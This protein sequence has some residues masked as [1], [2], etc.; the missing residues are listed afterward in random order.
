V[1]PGKSPKWTLER[2]LKASPEERRAAFRGNHDN[3]GL[4]PLAPD[5][6]LDVDDETPDGR[7]MEVFKAYHPNL[8]GDTLRHRTGRGARFYLYCPDVPQDQGKIV[9][10]EYLGIHDLRVEI[11]VG[12]GENIIIP[13]SVHLNGTVYIFE[14]IRALKANWLPTVRALDH[15]TQSDPEG[16]RAAS[17]A[18][19]DPN[20]KQAFRGNL[21]TLDIVAL[22]DHFGLLGE[23]RHDT[24]EGYKCYTCQCPWRDEHTHNKT[25]EWSERDTSSVIMF[26]SGNL[27][28]FNCKHSHGDQYKLPQFL[29]WCEEQE[30]GIVDQHCAQQWESRRSKRSETESED[31]RERGIDEPDGYYGPVDCSQETDSQVQ[32]SWPYPRDSIL[33]DFHQYTVQLSEAADCYIIGSILPIVG[34]LLGRNVYIPFGDTIIFPNLFSMIVGPAGDR[35]SFTIGIAQRLLQRL[36]APEALLSQIASSEAMFDEYDLCPDKIHVVDD[37]AQLLAGWRTTQ[38]GEKVAALFLRLYDCCGLDEA[39]VRNR[40]LTADKGTRRY[41]AQTSTS[42]L[43][44]ATPIDA[45][46]PAQK[47]QQGLSRRFLFYLSLVTAR[48]IEWPE[49]SSIDAMVPLFAPLLDFRGPVTLSK[50]ARELWGEFQRDNRRRKAEVP[51]ERESERYALSSEPVQV[52]KISTHFEACRAVTE[53]KTFL[54]GIRA[55]TLAL[56]IQHVGAC[57]ASAKMLVGRG[58]RHETRQQAEEIL[59]KIRDLFAPDTVYPDTIYVSRSRLTRKFC[60]HTSRKGALQ[61]D[62]LYLEIIPYLC[63]T[64]EAKRVFKQGKYEVYAFRATDTLPLVSPSFATNSP[65]G[66]PSFATNSPQRADESTRENVANLPNSPNSP[67]PRT[68]P[69]KNEKTGFPTNSDTKKERPTDIR[70]QGYVNLS[71]FFQ[72]DLFSKSGQKG[73]CESE[74]AEK[75]VENAEFGQKRVFVRGVGENGE[76][77]EFAPFSEGKI[78]SSSGEFVEKTL[79]QGGEFVPGQSFETPKFVYCRD[80]DYAAEL[81]RGLNA[82]PSPLISLDL[83]TFGVSGAKENTHYTGAHARVGPWAGKEALYPHLGEIRLLTV[84]VPGSKTIVFDFRALSGAELPWRSLF[85]TRETIVHNGMFE[86]KWLKAKLGF[87]LPKI[88]DTMHAAHLLQNGV[89]GQRN[90]LG[91]AVVVKRYLGRVVNKEEQLSDFG[92]EN[93]SFTQIAYAAGDVEFLDLLRQELRR[94][95]D[96]AE[97]G[98][99]L[100]AFD[101]DMRYL[102][103]LSEREGHGVRFDVEFGRALVADATNTAAAAESRLRELFGAQVLLTSPSQVKKALQGLLGEEIPDTSADTLKALVRQSL[104]C[105]LGIAPRDA[106]LGVLSGRCEAARLLFDYRKASAILTQMEGLLGFVHDDGRIYPSF[107]MG[108][109]RTGRI[110]STEPTLNNLSVDTGVRSCILADY[111]GDVVVKNDFSREEPTIVAFE[112]KPK[113]LIDD[114]VSGYDL[115]RGFAT[116]IFGVAY[117]EVSDQQIL[118]GKPNFL[119]VT[120]GET[121]RG[122][123]ASAAKE[124][125]ELNEELAAQ[126]IEGFNTRYPEIRAAINQAKAAARKRIVRYGKTR[127]GR[128]RLLLRCRVE[129][130]QEFL[131]GALRKA[132]LNFFGSVPRATRTAQLAHKADPP[133]G[134][135]ASAQVKNAARAEAIQTARKQWARWEREVLPQVMVQ[136]AAAWNKKEL[137]RESWDAQQLQINFKIQ[138][139]GSDVI[140]LSEIILESRLPADCRIMFSNHDETVVSCPREKAEEVKEIVQ[141]SMHEAFSLLYPGI[142]IR[143][144][145]EVCDT[146]K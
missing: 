18:Y 31:T 23:E 77:G 93:L 15:G 5:V 126:I 64:G 136:I 89:D 8:Y 81:I 133:T 9:I 55:D 73:V 120:Y 43:Y 116:A 98:S 26:K 125:R 143:S 66:S 110:T 12:A 127:L 129:P 54:E 60:Q 87:R 100:P 36:L 42:L 91:Y 124:G 96:C 70:A 144:E 101:L 53:K 30:A 108:G 63:E 145:P 2:R 22:A 4:V 41:I 46:F 103:I 117:E 67:T 29:A 79:G 97:G 40:K 37:A 71:D 132:K 140:R 59:V 83:E 58:R 75:T 52:L 104:D 130:T 92:V 121:V 34:R 114:I 109:T 7:G 35:K 10:H 27:P 106:G 137:W 112:F 74:G 138:A 61:T 69:Q 128:R 21:L 94:L 141:E 1:D 20:W 82:N 38:Y 51:E 118:T 56:A 115:Y 11:F 3:V 68:N 139:G 135:S 57:L 123:I 78:D 17:A 13:P 39:F 14:G 65:P 131:N 107:N 25:A 19:A 24:Q 105:L 76:F 47:Y 45:V 119:G 95:M 80:P 99:L 146:W 6:L 16:R 85:E 142:P 28:Q 122:L 72:Y 48:I 49:T 44:G 50:E 134:K 86:C 84:C 113:T 32:L 88:F 102:P 111:P 90:H 62:I 33:E